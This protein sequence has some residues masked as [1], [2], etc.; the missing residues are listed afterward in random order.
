MRDGSAGDVWAHYATFA[1]TISCNIFSKNLFDTAMDF[2][3]FHMKNRID[4]VYKKTKRA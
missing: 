2:D 3:N 4:P 1:P